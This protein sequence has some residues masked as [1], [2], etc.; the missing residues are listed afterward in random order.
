MP[1]RV[2]LFAL[3]LALFAVACDE[4]TSADYAEEA[5]AAARARLD[6]GERDGG[7]DLV[8]LADAG[9]PVADAAAPVQG[10]DAAAATSDAGE[11]QV[12]LSRVFKE[13]FAVS[14]CS[15]CHAATVPGIAFDPSS[16]ATIRRTVQEDTAPKCD[17]K[18]YITPGDPSRSFL[19]DVIS[20]DEPG[21]GVE[22]M[23]Q[24]QFPLTDEQ[25]ALVRTWIAQGARR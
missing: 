2:R 14:Q 7:D 6:Q 19:F 18:P 21:C 5:D 4:P 22:R 3:A 13:V 12:F 17:G 24:G 1:Y 25:I 10:E 23:P 20:K 11:P 16:I 9:A 15:L 8:E